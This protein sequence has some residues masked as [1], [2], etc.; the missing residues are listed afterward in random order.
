MRQKLTEYALRL[1][2][3]KR[4]TVEEMRKKLDILAKKLSKR[5]ES[6]EENTPAAAI[7]LVIE[8]LKELDY[9]NDQ[10]YLQNYIADRIRFRPRGEFMIRQELKRKGIDKKLL[11]DYLMTEKVDELGAA[12]KLLE[13]K[14]RRWMNENIQKQK[15]KAYR[16][17]A[18]KGFKPDNIYKAVDCCYNHSQEVGS[19]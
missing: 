10:S 4:Y 12:K 9:L 2:S 17:L 6:D 1:I 5:E 19:D 7:E 11:D 16:F 18:S 3:K 13:S 8:R 15:E 14:K